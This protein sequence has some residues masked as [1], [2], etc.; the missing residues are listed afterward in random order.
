MMRPRSVLLVAIALLAGIAALWL[1]CSSSSQRPDSKTPVS[2]IPASSPPDPPPAASA[3]ASAAPTSTA[4]GDSG[5]NP[6]WR[7]VLATPEQD[8]RFL[9]RLERETGRIPPEAEELV[10]L[11]AR[12]APTSELRAWARA[13]PAS[14]IK[15]RQIIAAWLRE[16]EGDAAAAPEAKPDARAPGPTS[17]IRP[18]RSLGPAPQRH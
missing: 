16:L 9:S 5:S 11:H 3:T 4:I 14:D 12:G 17:A 2:S 10:R 18:L 13:H 6:L 15:T 7:K 1:S 8:L